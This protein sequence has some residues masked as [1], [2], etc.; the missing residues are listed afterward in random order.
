MTKIPKTTGRGVKSQSL[1]SSLK[2]SENTPDSKPYSI[3][4][5][6]FNSIFLF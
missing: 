5:L 3:M 1:D 6:P 4:L 2:K